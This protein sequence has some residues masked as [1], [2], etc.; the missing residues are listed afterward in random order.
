M[1]VFHK[2]LT[3]IS[4]NRQDLSRPLPVFAGSGVKNDGAFEKRAGRHAYMRRR[5]EDDGRNPAKQSTFS[6]TAAA[7]LQEDRR[8]DA[9]V[10]MQ[11]ELQETLPAIHPRTTKLYRMH[12]YGKCK[13]YKVVEI[14]GKV[15]IM[16]NVKRK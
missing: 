5:L 4:Q 2:F 6:D 8:R 9:A 11:D 15:R 7:F 1:A 12:K 16:K 3:E 14:L 10:K 13:L